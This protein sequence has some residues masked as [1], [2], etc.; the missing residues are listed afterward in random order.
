MT[1]RNVGSGKWLIYAVYIRVPTFLL[2]PR[3]RIKA[4][5]SWCKKGYV[6]GA[7]VL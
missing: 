7:G 3:L 2:F 6:L 4:V 5:T 1:D